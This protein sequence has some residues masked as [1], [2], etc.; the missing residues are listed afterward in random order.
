M[1]GEAV[2]VIIDDEDEVRDSLARLLRAAGWRTQGFAS[3]ELFLAE[4]LDALHGC[5][6][7]DVN[8]PGICGPELHGI[9]RGRGIDLPIVY[10]T[11]RASVAV[12]VQAMKLGAV[13]FLEKPVDES[14]LFAAIGQAIE[15]HDAA[16]RLRR[17]IDELQARVR[18]L[19]ARE[20]EVMGHV[21]VGRLNKQIAAD[22]G[23]AEKTVK[24]HR[25]RVMTKMKVRSLAELVHLADELSA[26][27]GTDART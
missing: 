21:I 22:L 25:G 24:V 8:M 18:A 7:L 27:E 19:S 6:L 9:L 15:R 10:L 23:I 1:A 14:A 26:A 17:R 2:V 4:A 20:R 16:Q 13:D 3:A 11:G 12:G 5:V